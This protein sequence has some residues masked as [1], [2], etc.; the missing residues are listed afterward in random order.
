ML[1]IG[2]RGAAGYVPENTLI[3]IQKAI[4]LGVDFAGVDIRHTSDGMVVLLH[5]TRVDRTT[6]GKGLLLRCRSK[7]LRRLNAGNDEHIPTLEEALSLTNGKCGLMWNSGLSR[8]PP[9]LFKHCAR[10]ACVCV[11]TR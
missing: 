8:P 6:N 9:G 3:S 11:S 1:R 10:P 4:S 5:D 2:H 7:N